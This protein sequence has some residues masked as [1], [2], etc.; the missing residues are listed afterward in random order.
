MIPTFEDALSE[1]IA[2]YQEIGTP[3]DDLI[4]NLELQKFA[5]EDEMESRAAERAER[6]EI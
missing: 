3:N 1:L 4:M 6:G 5:L 2:K